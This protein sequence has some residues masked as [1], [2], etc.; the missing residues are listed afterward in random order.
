MLQAAIEA[1]VNE[2]LMQF[3]DRVDE[4]GNRLVV[5]NGY[6]PSREITT[7]LVSWKFL[8]HECEMIRLRL[9]SV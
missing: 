9:T 7:G 2:F 4:D 8:N 3:F 6:K 5:G 1:E